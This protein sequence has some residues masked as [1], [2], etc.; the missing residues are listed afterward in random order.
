[1]ARHFQRLQAVEDV[2]FREMRL[3]ERDLIERQDGI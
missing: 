1:M 2:A 3:S